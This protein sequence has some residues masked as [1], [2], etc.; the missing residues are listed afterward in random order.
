MIRF[1]GIGG[2]VLT[3]FLLIQAAKLCFAFGQGWYELTT[4]PLL[5]SACS[6][7]AGERT[8]KR[9][10]AARLKCLTFQVTISTA[11]AASADSTI[12]AS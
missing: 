6:H 10:A 7:Q 11:P 1:A 9:S 5:S 12:S 4:L 3:G 8:F 2:E